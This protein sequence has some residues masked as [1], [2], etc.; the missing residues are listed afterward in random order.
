MHWHSGQATAEGSTAFHGETKRGLTGFN[1]LKV[2]PEFKL[3]QVTQNEEHLPL[4]LQPSLSSV[5][6]V[7]SAAEAGLPWQALQML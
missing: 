2:D 3:E 1:I 5:V 6:T 4:L 7:G